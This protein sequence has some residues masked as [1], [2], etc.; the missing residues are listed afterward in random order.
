VQSSLSPQEPYWPHRLAT[1]HFAHSRTDSALALATEALRR[2]PDY[3]P[4]LALCSR[5]LFATGQHREA[6]DLLLAADAREPLPAALLAGLALH[7]ERLEAYDEADAIFARLRP[8][9][10]T[11]DV[12]VYRR[13]SGQ[14]F[15]QAL[16]LAEEAVA[17]DRDDAQKLNNYAVTLLYA[18]DPNKAK[19]LL[20]RAHELDAKLPGPLYNLAIVDRY[21][22]FD[23]AASRQWLGD[24]LRLS[25]DDP[26]GLIESFAQADA[27]AKKDGAK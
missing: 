13:L 6:A 12:L 10:A 24:Y 27:A 4:A 7:L 21:Y 15:K 5:L 22:F 19:E 16:A 25:S 18:G 9:P 8:E 20:L 17:R 23:E 11:D 14:D 26:D 3:A 2:D 1:I